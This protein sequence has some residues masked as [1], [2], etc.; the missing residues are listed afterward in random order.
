MLSGTA[1]RTSPFI[2]KKSLWERTYVWGIEHNLAVWSSLRRSFLRVQFFKAQLKHPRKFLSEALHTADCC[3]STVPRLPDKILS[4]ESGLLH[5]LQRDT[6][7]RLHPRSMPSDACA[8]LFMV[9]WIWV[10]VSKLGQIEQMWE[11][12]GS[13]LFS[14]MNARLRCAWQ[15][16]AHYTPLVVKGSH[17][18]RVFRYLH[19]VN[20][21]CTFVYDMYLLGTDVVHGVPPLYRIET[22]I[23]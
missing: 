6:K 1:I 18:S 22:L 13:L 4:P 14:R 16:R 9:I 8:R 21:S 5:G 15:V 12:L 10:F 23:C 7:W 11:G 2:L 3:W 20:I 19:L 17:H